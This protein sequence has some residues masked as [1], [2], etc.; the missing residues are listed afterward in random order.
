MPPDRIVVF[1]PCHS[2]DDFPTWLDDGEADELLAS[3][4]A[5]WHPWLI[6][7]VGSRPGWAS[8]DAPSGD[9][10][11]VLGIVPAS[12]DDRLMAALGDAHP[13]SRW[14]RRERGRPAIVAAALAALEPGAAAAPA[15]T[16]LAEDFH[17]LGLACLLS[18]LLARRMRSS[19]SLEATGFDE[20]V[21]AAAR[22]A[23]A[24]DE[25]LAREKL[26]ECF[27]A[28][29]AAR[30]QYYPVSFWLLDIVLLAGST[31]G[32]RLERELDAPVPLAVVATGEIVETLARTS[33]AV[34][35]RVKEGIASG[36]LS[37]V[38]G[39]FDATPLDC[40]TLETI[41]ESFTRGHAVCREHLG[42][43][44]VIFG[45]YTGG[46]SA[47]LPQLLSSLGYAGAIWSLFDGT[48]LPDPGTARIR[49]QS[50][51]GSSIDA[52]ARPPLDARS[53]AAILSL[54]DKIGDALDHDHTAIIQFAHHA[55]TASPWFDDLRRI[56]GW[57]DVLGRFVTPET[58]FAETAGA[59]ST[60]DFAPDAF[61]PTLPDARMAEEPDPI[62]SRIESARDEAV[63]IA[64]ARPLSALSRADAGVAGTSVRA[65]AE[66]PSHRRPGLL[67]GLF[68]G[69][70]AR[71][72][73]LILDNGAIRVRVHAQTGGMLS[74][75]RPDDRGNQLS[76]QLALRQTRPEP[77]PGAEWEDPQDRAEYSAMLADGVVRRGENLIV[78][79]GRLVDGTGRELGRFT[80]RFSLVGDLPLVRLGIDLRLARAPA[81]PLLEDY[82]ACR[83]AW[84]ENDDLDLCRSL[85]GESIVT[86][87]SR[88]TAPHFLELRGTTAARGRAAERILVCTGG[89]PWHVRST[90]HMVDAIL[91][92]GRCREGSFTLAVG[93]GIERPQAVALAVLLEPRGG[94]AAEGKP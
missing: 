88:F 90:P 31:L 48:P 50:P 14:V 7:A 63:R 34:L 69:G 17:A 93:L 1:L 42:A 57:S 9:M 43:V 76:Q 13:D 11:A 52:V 39:R 18:E 55:G 19:L 8:A 16:P 75:R 49:W 25:P 84:N 73:E 91:L 65:D 33:P 2:L 62:G 67:R 6:A 83:F 29:E 80:Q 21:V 45:Q 20:A 30:S 92:A 85:H 74:L 26:R 15:A 36:R 94:A 38:G 71:D 72:D 64:P 79:E 41:R 78:S 61:P 32:G 4:T 22:A 60:V 87:R 3:W 58:L 40:L 86:E 47:F 5:A 89:L 28:L 35:A 82:A 56:G 77:P 12:C 27:G 70:S 66:S 24:G 68:G 51:D 37:L 53:A 54:P 23:V 46:S 81:G 10:A 59:G 44:P